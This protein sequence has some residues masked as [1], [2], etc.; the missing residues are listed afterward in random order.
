ML[1]GQQNT[2]TREPLTDDP[3]DSPLERFAAGDMSPQ[4]FDAALPE[5]ARLVRGYLA[6]ARVHRDQLE[7]LAQEAMIRVYTRRQDR[8][9]TSVASLRA[10]LRVIC[11]N[12]ALSS[13]P[14][15]EPPPPTAVAETPHHDLD[16]RDALRHC[17]AALREPDQTVFRLRYLRDLATREIAELYGW[18]VRNCE[19][20]LARARQSLSSSLRREGYEA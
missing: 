6:F 11:R 19:H 10:W 20:V 12:L 8:T 15:M 9:G 4:A 7:D 17:I 14:R 16:L 2:D 3:S 1:A 18:K 5:L 13:R